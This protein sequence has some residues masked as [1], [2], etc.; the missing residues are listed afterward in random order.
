M[1]RAG[2]E[3]RHRA[4]TKNSLIFV[5]GIVVFLPHHDGHSL[6]VFE[7]AHAAL[8]SVLGIGPQPLDHAGIVV[9]I[10]EIMVQS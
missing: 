5:F 8:E 6:L 7:T 2:D 3:R 4:S 9:A 1:S 10:R